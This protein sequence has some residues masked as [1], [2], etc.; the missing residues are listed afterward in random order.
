MN[1]QPNQSTTQSP[2]SNFSISP[3]PLPKAEW[4]PPVLRVTPIA[5]TAGSKATAIGDGTNA[6]SS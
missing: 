1:E 6:F 3:S 5:E 2:I 4:T